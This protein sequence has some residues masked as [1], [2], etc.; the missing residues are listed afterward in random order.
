MTQRSRTT[1]ATAA[2]LKGIFDMKRS[3]Q[4]AAALAS[5]ALPVYPPEQFWRT[6]P[7]AV[8]FWQQFVA[9]GGL[10]LDPLLWNIERSAEL[11]VAQFVEN[12]LVNGWDGRQTAGAF[13]QSQACLHVLLVDLRL[14]LSER[15][16]MEQEIY[17]M[18]TR[19]TNR[20][21]VGA[22]IIDGIAEPSD[23]QLLFT[24]EN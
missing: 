23:M 21:L 1:V 12:G 20:A 5:L 9:R 14:Q 15:Q 22:A 13:L 3:G 6:N 7:M 2:A 17:D 16:T 19:E 8:L 18:F 11:Q 10:V 4:I 24:D